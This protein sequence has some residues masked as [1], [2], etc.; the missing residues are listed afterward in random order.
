[1]LHSVL[2]VVAAFLPALVVLSLKEDGWD[3][4]EEIANEDLDLEVNKELQ[5]ERQQDEEEAL[6]AERIRLERELKQV[7]SFHLPPFA[8]CLWLFLPS[9]LP[10][11]ASL[12]Q[13]VGTTSSCLLPHRTNEQFSVAKGG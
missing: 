10:Q 2:I 5:R 13:Y 8:H 4:E 7:C 12:D 9:V 3:H 1:M 11:C 6:E